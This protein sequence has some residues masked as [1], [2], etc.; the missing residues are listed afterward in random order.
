MSCNT[1]YPLIRKNP[2]GAVT[3][4]S[5]TYLDCVGFML[6][7]LGIPHNINILTSGEYSRKFITRVTIVGSNPSQKSPDNSA[8]HPSTKSRQF[9]D[10]WFEGHNCI[11]IEYMNL[12]NKKTDNNKQLT[13][14]QI[15]VELE[16]IKK[17]FSFCDN[18]VACGKVA[19][20][21][22]TMAGIEHFEMP[23][24]SGLNHFWNDKDAAEKKIKEMK[25][26][27]GIIKN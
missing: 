12:I 18:I 24:P 16:Q 11:D 7:D 22:L 27:L 9:V 23:H 17:R 5:V 14:S 21:G 19:S 13:K 10:K 3:H 4:R 20:M 26:W 1:K 8:F 15:R 2:E 25:E 6:T